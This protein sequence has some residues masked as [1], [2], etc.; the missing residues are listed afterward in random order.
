MTAGIDFVRVVVF[1]EFIVD[2]AGDGSTYYYDDIEVVT[3]LGISDTTTSLFTAFPNP[4]STQWNLESTELI[5]TSEIYNMIG[6]SVL[7]VKPN[8]DRYTVD[9][10]RL[11]AG[12]YVAHVE[13][14]EGKESVKIIKK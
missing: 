14:T 8:K 11:Q 6:Q 5:K 10:S 4:M 2:L 12:L 3:P 13:T 7:K 1:F 9:V